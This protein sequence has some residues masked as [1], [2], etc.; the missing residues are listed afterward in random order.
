VTR[1][2]TVGIHKNGDYFVEKKTRPSNSRGKTM[3]LATIFFA[4]LFNKPR[5]LPGTASYV[6]VKESIKR[7]ID[8]SYDTWM[9]HGLGTRNWI[10]GGGGRTTSF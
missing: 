2:N 5:R 10:L 6:A 1:D 8:V 3:E 4:W 9:A 7:K